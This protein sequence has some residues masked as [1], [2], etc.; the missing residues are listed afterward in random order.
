MGWEHPSTD[1]ITA[2]PALGAK[3]LTHTAENG[4]RPV[5]LV[6]YQSTV[7]RAVGW[8]NSLRGI[9]HSPLSRGKNSPLKRF[10]HRSDD[11]T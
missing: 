7:G 2:L 9:H 3:I 4:F 5:M 11:Q 1:P 6:T 10:D 8:A